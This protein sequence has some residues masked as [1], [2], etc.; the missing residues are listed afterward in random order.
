M[1]VLQKTKTK[2]SGQVTSHRRHY[3]LELKREAWYWRNNDN[4]TLKQ[5]KAKVKEKYSDTIPDGTL[6]GFYNAK[7]DEY[8]KQ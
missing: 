8:F 4:L 7:F 3:S 1:V 2:K 5:L 6:C